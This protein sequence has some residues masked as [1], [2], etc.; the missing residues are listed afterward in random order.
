V[1]LLRNDGG[2]AN[3][4]L[5]VRLVGIR[6]GSGKNNHYGIGAKIELRAGDLYQMQLVTDANVHFGLGSHSDVDVVRIVWTNGTPQNIFTPDIG[7]E[8]VE[9]QQLKGSCPFLY[10][11]N[12]SE[13]VFVKDIMWRSAL[14][15]PMGIMGGEM[16]YAFADASQDYLRVPGDML[17]ASGGQY[18]LQVTDELWETIYFDEARLLAVDHPDSLEV[19]VDEKFDV[20]PYPELKIYPVVSKKVP[21]SAKDGFGNDVLDLVREKDDRYVATFL[22]EDYQGIT[23]MHELVLDPGGISASDGNLHLFLNG[24]IFPTDASIN[25]ALSQGENTRTVA[26]FLQVMNADGQWETVIPNLGFPEGKNKTVIAGLSD[27]YLSADRRVKICSNMEIYWDYIFFAGVPEDAVV[28]TTLM[29]PVAADHHYR[30]F[31]RMYRKGGRYGPHWFDYSEVQQGPIWYDLRGMYTRFGDVK[32]L[33]Q[34]KDDKYIIVGSGEETT[35]SFD[36]DRA[37][38]LPE[39]WTRDFLV[40]TTG[41]VKDG[42]MNTATGNFVEPLPF[43]GMKHYPYGP[44]E[45]RRPDPDYGEYMRKYNTREITGETFRRMVYE[46]STR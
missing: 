45:G 25:F 1:R 33:L 44:G 10:T 28:R 32:E 31:S 30:G 13:F 34:E 40:Y 17:R 27:K 3:N 38:P 36:A 2:D 20:P 46:G 5:K 4:H 9:E 29:R 15:M 7:K 18:T 24:W 6:T 41:W 22:R 11:W 19:Y 37:G 39:G 8:L 12:G 23:E 43:H 26:P 16:A 14:G 42:D 35:I 21:V